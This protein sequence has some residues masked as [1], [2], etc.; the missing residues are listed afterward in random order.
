MHLLRELPGEPVRVEVS[1]LVG[2]RIYTPEP[3]RGGIRMTIDRLAG[4]QR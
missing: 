2:G 3:N 4:G 1:H